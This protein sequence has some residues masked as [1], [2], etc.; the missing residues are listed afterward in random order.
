[1]IHTETF[2]RRLRELRGKIPI[3]ELA[4]RSG[5]ATSALYNAEGEKP[6]SWKTVEK[7]YG[8]L[9]LGQQQL[10]HL[11]TLWALTQT[12]KPIGLYEMAETMKT[13][14]ME[15]SG[16]TNQEDAEMLKAMATMTLPERRTLIQFARHFSANPATQRMVNAWMESVSN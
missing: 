10:V 13:V 6:V 3:K 11:L 5:V 14:V 8:P 4:E 12:T 2:S 15:E 9:C 7:A 1:M 16:K